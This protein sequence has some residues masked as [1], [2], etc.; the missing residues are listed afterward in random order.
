MLTLTGR[1]VFWSSQRRDRLPD[2]SPPGVARHRR[3]TRM[4]NRT[5]GRPWLRD[6]SGPDTGAEGGRERPQHFG[7]RDHEP[8]DGRERERLACVP[9]GLVTPGRVIG[10]GGTRERRRPRFSPLR[11]TKTGLRQR[12]GPSSWVVRMTS[13]RELSR[14]GPGM[15]RQERPTARQRL[16]TTPGYR[17]TTDNDRHAGVRHCSI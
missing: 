9:W 8:P 17:T 10:P 16:M 13:S 3:T 15:P 2:R 11:G 4:A 12:P 5:A 7:R 6:I 14:R 1:P